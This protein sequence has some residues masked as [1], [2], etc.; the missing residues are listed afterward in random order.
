MQLIEKKGEKVYHG[1][2]VPANSPIPPSMPKYH[3]NNA[4]AY[5]LDVDKAKTIR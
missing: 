5:N 1:L 3:N 4:G 2:R